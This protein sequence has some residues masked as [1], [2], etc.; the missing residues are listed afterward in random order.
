MVGSDG[1]DRKDAVDRRYKQPFCAW[2]RVV[3][4]LPWELG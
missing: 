1:I 2:R 3:S 4:R